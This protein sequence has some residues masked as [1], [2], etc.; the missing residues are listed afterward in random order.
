MS[1]SRPFFSFS[2]SARRLPRAA[3]IANPVLQSKE[4]S[5]LHAARTIMCDSLSL[6]ISRHVTRIL[7][8]LLVSAFDPAPSAVGDTA[9]EREREGEPPRHNVI[10]RSKVDTHTHI[11]TLTYIYTGILLR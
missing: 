6:Y 4:A 8:L 2:F 7:N 3:Y 5:F 9:R 11:D 10:A 1:E